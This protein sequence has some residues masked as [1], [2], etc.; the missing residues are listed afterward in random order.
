MPKFGFHFRPY[1]VGEVISNNLM[2]SLFNKDVVRHLVSEASQNT[3]DAARARMSG[4]R[5]RLEFNLHAVTRNS[6]EPFG[7]SEVERHAAACDEHDIAK[8]MPQDAL[9]VLTFEDRSGGVD[10]DP[11]AGADFSTPLGRYTFSIGS[12]VTGKAGQDNGRHGLGSGSGA[13]ISKSRCMYFTSTRMD[14]STIASGRASLATHR[15]DGV[16]YSSEARLGVVEDVSGEWQGILEADD[17]DILHLEL[18]FSRPLDAPGLSCAVID[19]VDGINGYS[20]VAGVLAWQFLQVARGE[21]EFRVVDETAG[22]DVQISAETID[23]VIASELFRATQHAVRNKGKPG[24]LQCILEDLPSILAF[25]RGQPSAET[26]PSV[27]LDGLQAAVPGLRKQ[28]FEGRG[29]GVSFRVAGIHSVNGPASGSVSTWVKPLKS[30]VPGYDVHVRDSIVNIKKAAGRYSLTVSAGDACSVLLGDSEDPSHMT[31][32]QPYARK[33]GWTKFAEVLGTFKDAPAILQAAMSGD[34]SKGDR[35]SLARFFPM[36][37]SDLGSRIDGGAPDEASDDSGAVVVDGESA[38][39]Q[40]FAHR[41]D[42]RSSTVTLTLT[43][44]AQAACEEGDLKDLVVKAEYAGS[45]PGLGSLTD[46]GTIFSVEQ[47]AE[48]SSVSGNELTV[49]GVGPDLRI[50]IRNVDFN[51]DLRIEH[52]LADMEEAA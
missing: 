17:A 38:Y 30:G 43:A 46:T 9:K 13:I 29:V 40:M 26:F 4:S 14:G 15:I 16:Y 32:T 31:Y 1:K 8:S 22:I 5:A 20:L 10:G 39:E 6:L 44:A 33:R 36:P 34:A 3:L 50:V 12:G 45:K 18:G 48:T 41:N 7:V 47:G 19:P 2:P 21:I 42:R 23:A 35:V 28:W 24:Q 37:G 51:R 25:V 52:D 49:Y 11:R 27:A